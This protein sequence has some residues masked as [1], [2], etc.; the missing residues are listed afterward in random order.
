VRGGRHGGGR[1]RDDGGV[2]EGRERPPAARGQ[3]RPGP[4]HRRPRRRPHHGPLHGGGVSCCRASRP[5]YVLALIFH[6]PLSSTAPPCWST[7]TGLPS[8]STVNVTAALFTVL[9]T[10]WVTRTPELLASG[11]A[12]CCCSTGRN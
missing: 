1:A 11:P 4:P 7:S 8:S 10:T 6:T 3:R 9:R 5:Q 12:A 2:Q